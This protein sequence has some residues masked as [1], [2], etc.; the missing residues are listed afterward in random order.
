M[1]AVSA[2]LLLGLAALLLA[3]CQTDKRGVQVDLGAAL[4]A[5]RQR[6]ERK[7]SRAQVERM[8]AALGPQQLSDLGVLYERE[9]RLDRAA[10]AYQHAA[11][12]NPR[13]APAYVNLGNVLRKQGKTEEALFRYRQAMNADPRSF[14]AANNFGDLCA[15]KGLYLKEATAR[16]A[17]LVDRA[18]PHRAYGLDTLGW[19]YHRQGEEAKAAATLEAALR[20]PSLQEEKLRAL[21]GEH[22]AAVRAAGEARGR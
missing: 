10:W 14:E 3:G 19:L 18:G 2:R 21:I 7:P 20:D 8:V 22:L 13:F 6:L 5:Y 16:L 12:R 4:R 11:W 15:E 1:K 9:G 17:P